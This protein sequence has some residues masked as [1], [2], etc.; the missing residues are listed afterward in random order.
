MQKVHIA[1]LRWPAASNLG[2]VLIALRQ[3]RTDVTTTPARA[4]S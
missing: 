4:A 2:L 1:V 3:R